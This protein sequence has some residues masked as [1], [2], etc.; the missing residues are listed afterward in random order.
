MPM[1]FPSQ[2]HCIDISQPINTQTACFPGDIPF[3][4]NITISHAD[5]GAGSGIINLTALTMSPHVGTHADAPVHIEGVLSDNTQ[6]AGHLALSPYVGPCVVIDLASTSEMIDDQRALEKLSTFQS[7]PPRVLFKTAT[8]IRYDVFEPAYAYFSETLVKTLAGKGVVLMGIDTP[9]VDHIA[10]KTLPAHH[11]LLE[12][13][14]SWLENLDLT[15]VVCG[16][17]F[18]VA[19]P[20]KFTEL[21]ASPVRAVLLSH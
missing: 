21:E 3:S 18:L 13:N 19:L 16:E 8:R 2:F 5:S 11:Q 17:Y 1:P 9:S 10:S 7:L 15:Q 12:N 4:K 6:T 20:L 14:M